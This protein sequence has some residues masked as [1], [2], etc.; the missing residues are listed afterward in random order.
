MINGPYGFQE[1]LYKEKLHQHKD[2]FTAAPRCH[3]HLPRTLRLHTCCSTRR[4]SVAILG[5]SRP[6]GPSVVQSPVVER[7]PSVVVL[8]M[9]LPVLPGPGC[10]GFGLRS[11]NIC[12]MIGIGTEL[13]HWHFSRVYESMSGSASGPVSGSRSTVYRGASTKGYRVVPKRH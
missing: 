13:G 2:N 9:V 8:G 1:T 7:S 6:R 11:P 5:G 3:L 12:N 4:R 10:R